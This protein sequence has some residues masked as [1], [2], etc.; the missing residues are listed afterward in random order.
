MRADQRYTNLDLKFWA[1][2]RTIGQEIGY[3][4]RKKVLRYDLRRSY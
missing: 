4:K 2:V 1:N 3:S